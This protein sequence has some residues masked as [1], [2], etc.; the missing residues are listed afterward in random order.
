M[1]MYITKRVH[2]PGVRHYVAGAL[3]P[4]YGDNTRLA[5]YISKKKGHARMQAML[6]VRLA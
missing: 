2:N 5:E 4:L 6:P 1:G 3:R